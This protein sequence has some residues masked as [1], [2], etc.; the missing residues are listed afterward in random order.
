M[1]HVAKDD[2]EICG[3]AP[4]VDLHA[5]RCRNRVGDFILQTLRA[6]FAPAGAGCPSAGAAS[7]T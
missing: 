4:A 5:R 2:G 3:L 1:G 6:A 7:W